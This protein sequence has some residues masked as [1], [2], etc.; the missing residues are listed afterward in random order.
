MHTQS[1]ESSSIIHRLLF[2]DQG[3]PSFAGGVILLLAMFGAAA[4]IGSVLYVLGHGL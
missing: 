4:I 3:Q 2:D 1:N